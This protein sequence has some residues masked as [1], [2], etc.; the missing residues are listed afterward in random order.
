MTQGVHTGIRIP[1]FSTKFIKKFK[2]K[3]MNFKSNFLNYLR[4]RK[5]Q[6]GAAIALAAFVTIW[7]CKDNDSNVQNPIDM[8]SGSDGVIQLKYTAEVFTHVKTDAKNGKLTGL[9]EIASMPKV[10][11]AEIAM[12]VYADGTCDMTT[13]E[14]TP[15][16]QPIKLNDLTP[17]SERPMGVLTRIDRDG[18]VKVFDKD[19]KEI[20]T[21]KMNQKFDGSKWIELIKKDRQAANTSQAISYIFGNKMNGVKATLEEAR[22]T[23]GIITPQGDGTILVRLG[24][25]S[26]GLDTRGNDKV[27]AESVIDTVQNIVKASALFDKQSSKMLGKFVYTFKDVNGS[28]ELTHIYME[29]FNPK[30]PAD[31]QQ[32][33]ISVTELSGVALKINL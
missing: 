29:S 14:L 1:F 3:I 17:P 32:K 26:N 23:G 16:F 8:P 5:L 22:K 31:R 13:R 9:E 30:S 19:N 28:K 11:K 7:A 4:H 24:S 10:N 25:P 20:R 2:S 15:S 21:F 12:I 33:M 18:N 6:L 27:F